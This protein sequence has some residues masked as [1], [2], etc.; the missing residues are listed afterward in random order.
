MSSLIIIS[1]PNH[2]LIS[3]PHVS[4]PSTRLCALL[5]ARSAPSVLYLKFFFAYAASAPIAV[6]VS[7]LV[8]PVF[9][10]AE[11][12]ANVAGARVLAKTSAA[13]CAGAFLNVAAIYMVPSDLF[14]LNAA[15]GSSAQSMQGD[16]A[17]KIAACVA[18]FLLVT[19]PCYSL[20]WWY[21][22]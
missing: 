5:E 11:N 8:L 18:G 1:P 4:C 12:A 3:S 13:L 9:S 21:T 19:A 20:P 2:H 14:S 10:R 7:E 22:A 16:K 15:P 17:R 6:A